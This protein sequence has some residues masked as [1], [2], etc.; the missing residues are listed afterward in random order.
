MKHW[1]RGL[2]AGLFAVLTM[3]ALAQDKAPNDAQI[4]AIVVEAN[5]F[6]IEM[7]KLAKDRAK[8]KEVRDF[9]QRMVTDHAGVNKQV[10]AL[11]AKLKLKPEDSGISRSLQK[12]GIATLRRFKRLSDG[13]FD[14]SYV[15]H[16][17][18][19]HQAVLDMIDK[20]LL[21]NAQNAQ[22]K[23]LIEK[24]RPAIDAHLQH[25]KKIESE[26]K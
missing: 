22:L 7:G 6:D 11:A 18:T 13:E 25:A 24:V 2:M 8:N 5:N 12:D 26:T 15:G 14:R 3:P 20:T 10:R 23:D 19:F 17:V 4:A 1:I 21:P 16:E 9:A